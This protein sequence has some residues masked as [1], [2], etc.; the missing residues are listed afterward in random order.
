M[1]PKLK[2]WLPLIVIIMIM[3]I[4]IY[5]SKDVKLN[6]ALNKLLNLIILVL[7]AKS[8]WRKGIN[9]VVRIIAILTVIFDFLLFSGLALS[10]FDLG[11]VDLGSLSSHTVAD[12]TTIAAIAAWTLI[13]ALGC[14]SLEKRHH[15][16]NKG[17][18]D[19]NNELK[20]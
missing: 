20:T 4:A 8:L 17:S 19:T 3:A 12:R 10:F 14:L 9:N 15:G 13:L 18:S 2:K 1:N 6:S 7:I 11:D 5:T 16:L